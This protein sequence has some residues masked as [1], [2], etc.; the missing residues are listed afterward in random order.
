MASAHLSTSVHTPP[1]FAFIANL[2]TKSSTKHRRRVW[3]FRDSYSQNCRPKCAVQ[4]TS[5]RHSA[6]L[7]HKQKDVDC[8][9]S[10]TETGYATQAFLTL[11]QNAYRTRD[12]AACLQLVRSLMVAINK[13]QANRIEKHAGPTA[14]A[15]GP[16]KEKAVE[17]AGFQ[18][19]EACSE[20]PSPAESALS[21]ASREY[22]GNI[23]RGKHQGLMR[24]LVEAG[25]LEGALEYL[26]MLP[27]SLMLCS[28]LL[29]ECMVANDLPG[30]L[31]V[32]KVRQSTSSLSWKGHALM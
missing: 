31:R 12:S 15:E 13:T 10:T 9:V 29:K 4:G 27:P 25:N 22:L 23:L 16:Q 5:L 8:E 11:F 3:D 1:S 7:Y 18:A 30:V 26:T 20:R 32:I 19:D 14:S 2:F 6:S 21:C 17:D 24:L 28:A